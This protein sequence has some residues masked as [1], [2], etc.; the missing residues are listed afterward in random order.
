MTHRAWVFTLNNPPNAL[1]IE[2]WPVK[3]VI[4]QKEVGESGT[5]HFQGYAEFTKPIRLSGVRRLLGTAHWEPRKGTRDEARAY[6]SKEDTRVEGPW[7]YGDWGKG[8]Q[9]SRTDVSGL[10]EKVMSGAPLKE[11][12]ESETLSFLKY[13]RSV[14]KARLLYQPKRDWPVEVTVLVGPTGVGKS[15][16]CREVAPNAY[17]K[18]PSNWWDGYDGQADVV[19]DDYYGWLPFHELLRVLD[20]YEHQ[21]QSKGGNTQ[22]LAKR[23]WIT[24]NKSPD[25]WYDQ[26][27]R[28]YYLKSLY[29]RLTKLIYV[30]D[31]GEFQSCD[32]IDELIQLAST[33]DGEGGG[34]L[35]VTEF[36]EEPA[37]PVL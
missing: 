13:S 8:G 22:L 19:L 21:V 27:K 35:A 3:Y 5:P 25:Q 31:D 9:G 16:Y 33:M 29:R 1:D 14:E 10:K 36:E 6:S 7:E 30:D 4:Y 26:S 28:T 18:Q 11:I 23:I 32:S 12:F 2:D 34:R 37:S 15:K 20:R 17:W 24:S